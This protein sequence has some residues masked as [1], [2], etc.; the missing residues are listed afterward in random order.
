MLAYSARARGIRWAVAGI[1]IVGSCGRGFRFSY[2][3]P[4][5]EFMNANCSNVSRHCVCVYRAVQDNIPY[6]DYRRFMFDNGSL[7]Q[8]ER[9]RMNDE[10]SQL[11]NQCLASLSEGQTD[12]ARIT[13]G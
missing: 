8:Q 13:A 4:A 11:N 1:M 3:E 9:Q 12:T 2:P 10:L 6:E 5:Q 7:S